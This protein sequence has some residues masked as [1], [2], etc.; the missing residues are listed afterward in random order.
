M[1]TNETLNGLRLISLD[2]V[3][4]TNDE[5]RWLAAD[6]ASDGTL[7]RARRQTA[8]RGR[9]GR[10]WISDPGNLYFSLVL[11]PGCPLARA[12][13]I[14]FVVANAVADAVAAALPE[15]APVGCKWPNDVLVAGRKVSGML[16]ESETGRDGQLEWLV[17]GVGINIASHPDDVRFPA[18]SL[19]ACGAGDGVSAEVMLATFCERFRAGYA[20]W[21][22][23]G[24]E[25]I[26]RA[27]LG[28]AV[29]RGSVLRASL[30]TATVEGVF[31]DM[32]ASGALVI[33]Q[34]AGTR[35]TVTAGDVYFPE[36]P[37]I[38]SGE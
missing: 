14:G 3:G 30:A 15:G 21:S 16:L 10:T 29:G 27:W 33:R 32:D 34:A 4:S 20:V 9:L 18:S 13:Q 6:G 38:S 24:F 35:V 36:T 25:P 8:G 5:A 19:T 22:Q 2:T 28:R 37:T 17:A 23:E 7:V 12:G 31:E 1:A 11:R 26:R